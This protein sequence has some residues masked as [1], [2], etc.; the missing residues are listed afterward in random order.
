MNFLESFEDAWETVGLNSV[1]TGGLWREDLQG[2]SPKTPYAV[3][4]VL[5]DTEDLQTAGQQTEVRDRLVRVDIFHE[6]KYRN[7]DY[8]NAAR[9]RIKFN[10]ATFLDEARWPDGEEL[11]DLRIHQV[12][13]KYDD[14]AKKGS[15][16]YQ[17]TLELYY[18]LLWR[19]SDLADVELESSGSVTESLSSHSS[20][21]S[22]CS[23]HNA[24]SSSSSGSSHSRTSSTSSSAYSSSR[25]ESSLSSSESSLS[26]TSRNSSGTSLSESSGLGTSSSQL[27]TE[28][29][30]SQSSRS[31]SSSSQSA[32]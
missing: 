16:F 14:P 13:Q 11:I 27:S 19:A 22:E 21:S 28:S 8:L 9:I 12:R 23:G 3:W 6:D 29:S 1:I 30:S 18:K 2:Q 25:S 5:L 4:M 26:R 32:G 10:L 31:S 20:G 17:G 7:W 15:G 24:S